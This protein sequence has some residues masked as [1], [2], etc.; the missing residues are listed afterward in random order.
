MTERG[1]RGVAAVVTNGAAAL[2]GFSGA[3][4]AGFRLPWSILAAVVCG[5]I[6][7]LL[8]AWLAA[9]LSR[10]LRERS[11]APSGRAHYRLTDV[12]PGELGAGGKA[13]SLAAMRQGGLPV[14]DGVVL[15]PASFDGDELT[16]EASAWLTGELSRL[17]RE[18]QFAVRSSALSEDSAS[19]SFAGAYESVLEVSADQVPSALATVR[20]SGRAARVAAY[21]EARGA[22]DT[23][24]VAV[25]VQLMVP[26][27]RA[28][29]LFTVHPLTRELDTM[30]GNTV[31]GLGESLVSG[32]ATATE[33]TLHR[34][35]GGFTGPDELRPF[36]AKLHS[37][38]HQIETVFGGIPQDIEWAIADG[39]VW[40]LQA[41]PITTLSGY[42][43][44][45]AEYNDSLTGNCLWSATN[46][47]EA[48]PV[49][50]TPLTIS[51][52]R[53][54]QANGGP[55]MAIRGR[56]MAGYI[57]GRPY[58]NLSVQITARRGRN[59]KATPR[60]VY[61]KMAGWWGELPSQVPVTLVPMTQTDW[62]DSGLWL[63]GSLV[64][65]V[66]YRRQLDGYL[67]RNPDDCRRLS[68]EI[69][70][71][72]TADELLTLWHGQLLPAAIRSFWMTIALSSDGPAQL[73]AELRAR[74]D[75][76]LVSALFG[77][78]SGLA[79]RLESLG[80]SLGL[81]EVRAGRLA[82]A[83]YLARFGHRGVN[84]IELAWPRPVEDPNWLDA[85]LAAATGIELDDLAARRAAGYQQALSSLPAKERA[86]VER[87]LRRAARQA[88]AREA[89]RSEGVRGTW[90]L[91]RFALR[92][93]ELLGL[94]LDVFYLTIEELLAG[95]GGQPVDREL[96]AERRARHQQLLEL[97][98]LP[99]VIYGAFDPLAWADDPNRRADYWVFGS[100]ERSSDRAEDSE[101]PALVHGFAGAVGQVEGVVR[102]LDDFAQADQL[103][104]G[105]VL[106]TQ[107]TNIGWTPLFPR[108]AAI[109][110]DLGAPLSHAAIVARELGIPAVVG[111]ADATARLATGDRVLVDGA[112]GTV[113][114]LTR[115]G[116]PA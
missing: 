35:D 51:L 12:P 100:G 18:R 1:R 102:R 62:Q 15:L 114:L 34:P 58:A 31:L 39:T 91:R 9:G 72:R 49:P 95:L 65:M 71:S 104:P 53:Y 83:D 111:C 2:V 47:S 52:M 78:L 64:K 88:A 94:G 45:I 74:Y 22:D 67:A 14:P 93:G 108:A 86:G 4:L 36:G 50:Q 8:G 10:W 116:A 103:R 99:A 61:Q 70:A 79:G 54:Q 106:V 92:A 101:D 63:L 60:E 59:A 29:V 6:G 25:V 105:E 85:Q 17:G 40:V 80:P 57:G 19:A 66:G 11:Y 97:P 77:N 46:L 112:A 23:G 27:E 7:W 13:R 16:A 82:P 41:R 107:L 68:D 48:N 33:F 44:R 73:E 43:P 24:Q 32:A 75:A 5:T 38:G 26:A 81:A 69:A 98:Q 87:K 89:A 30:L 96:L 113:R 37:L 55:S 110:T 28:G 3:W 115:A 56:E 42:Q 90:V 109:V 21:A 76:Q 84:E 20:A